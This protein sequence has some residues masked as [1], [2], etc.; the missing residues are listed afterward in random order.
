MIFKTLNIFNIQN[1]STIKTL[2]TKELKLGMMFHAIK[3]KIATLYIILAICT[4]IIF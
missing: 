3:K 4:N 2:N 1:I